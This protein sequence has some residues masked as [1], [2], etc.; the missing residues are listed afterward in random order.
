M[1]SMIS[2]D[3]YLSQTSRRTFWFIMSNNKSIA[4]IGELSYL[5]KIIICWFDAIN[6]GFI[7]FDVCDGGG[8]VGWWLVVGCLFMFCFSSSIYT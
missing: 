6:Y 8:L 1:I 7:S 5:H 4:V 3:F 2:V